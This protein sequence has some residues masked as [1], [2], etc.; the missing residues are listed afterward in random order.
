MTKRRATPAA[1]RERRPAL[2]RAACNYRSSKGLPVFLP[3]FAA[4]C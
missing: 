2:S 4:R 3:A 1:Q